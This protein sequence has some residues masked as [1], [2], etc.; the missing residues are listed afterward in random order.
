MDHDA[1]LQALL[2]LPGMW[3]AKVSRDSKWVAWSWFRTGP[4]AEV[5]AVPTDGSQAPL[6]LTQTTEN[7]RLVSWAPSSKAV[8][9]AQDRGGDE[10]FRLFRV[11]LDN[12]CQ[13][14]LLTDAD[15]KY[16]LRGGQLHPNGR[17]LVYGANYDFEKNQEL[18]P[19]WLYRQDLVSGERLVLARPEKGV[20]MEPS[21]NPQGTHVVYNRKDIHPAG[22]QI[23]IVDINGEHDREIINMGDDVEVSASWFP[24]GQRLLVIQKTKTHHRVGIWELETENLRWLV[25]DPGR[26]IEKASVPHGSAYIVLQEVIDART[27][28]SI[29]APESG[30]EIPLPEVS[31]NLIPMAPLGDGEWA[32]AYYSATQPGDL[33]R[34]AYKNPH[35]DGF[36]SLTRVWER[37]ELTPEDFTPAEDYRWTSSDGLSIQ[38]WLYRPQGETMGTIVYVHG[39]PTSHS[40]DAINIQIQLYARAGFVVLDPNYR[41]STGFS[42]AFQ[43]SIKKDGWGGMEQIDIR[44]GIESLIEAGISSAGKVGL[45]GTS[46][47]GYSAWCG[48]TRFPVDILAAAAPVCGMTDLVVDYESTRP[49]LRPLSEKMMGG[50]PEDVP[51]VYYK[52]SPIHFV[53]DIKG[54]LLIVQG[55]KDPNVTPENLRVVTSALE[56][57]EIPYETLVFDDEGHGISRPENQK[58]L[59]LRLLDFFSEA[60]TS[61]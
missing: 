4:V 40:Q 20:Y 1:Y 37:T 46:Y 21:L 13:M 38:G 15:P 49:D 52:A 7:T 53:T 57:H 29:L 61:G 54:H 55:A 19:T 14:I 3:G 23:W 24:D 11:N 26:N 12:P 27:R 44:S 47:G 58:T 8:V 16:F 42:V 22:E 51:E 10:R 34:F 43:E 39:G 41:G 30:L 18:E 28:C 48:I 17:W 9:V 56:S 33:V 31:G 35:P 50:S 5:F 6:Q 2:S 59:Y 36:L 25:D 32:G 60:F 45:T